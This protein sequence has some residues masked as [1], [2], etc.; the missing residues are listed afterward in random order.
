M[1]PVSRA[2]CV[3]LDFNIVS[4]SNTTKL[5]LGLSVVKISSIYA[6]KP[7]LAFLSKWVVLL[8]MN[9]AV[10]VVVVFYMDMFP[11]RDLKIVKM[12]KISIFALLFALCQVVPLNWIRTHLYPFAISTSL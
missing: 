7:L 1:A 8:C 9:L 6:R 4:R 5:C 2:L 11:C 10:V 3:T 12:P